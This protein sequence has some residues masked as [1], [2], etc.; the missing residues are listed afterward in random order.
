M[1]SWLGYIIKSLQNF[2][3]VETGTV[4][5]LRWVGESTSRKFSL[6]EKSGNGWRCNHRQIGGHLNLS[7]RVLFIDESC[8]V[9]HLFFLSAFNTHQCLS[10][11]FLLLIVTGKYLSTCSWQGSLRVLLKWYYTGPSTCNCVAAVQSWPLKGQAVIYLKWQQLHFYLPAEKKKILPALHCF[12]SGGRVNAC[13]M[14]L[15]VVL[16][17]CWDRLLC[18][19]Q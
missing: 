11:I 9:S 3:V 14:Y 7:S 16:W 4:F 12:D 8:D 17:E 5:W 10:S 13:S 1:C 2:S 18:I 6:L 19:A 15:H